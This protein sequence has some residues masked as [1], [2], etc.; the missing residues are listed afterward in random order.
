MANLISVFIRNINMF[1]PALNPR[2]RPFARSGHMVRNKLHWDANYFQN[3]GKSGWTGSSFF[4]LGGQLC[5]LRPSVI[6]SVPCDRIV[7]GPILST[8]AGR[9]RERRHVIKVLRDNKYPLRFIRV[10][11]ATTALSAA[12][13]IP[14]TLPALSHLQRQLLLFFRM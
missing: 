7:Q 6:Y 3:K 10:A 11:S 14:A 1:V 2:N 12:I 9:S 13:Q 5:N 4:V 8:N